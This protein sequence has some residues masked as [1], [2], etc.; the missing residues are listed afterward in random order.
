MPL[1]SFYDASAPSW[2]APIKSFHGEN[3]VYVCECKMDVIFPP[4]SLRLRPLLSRNLERFVTS[5]SGMAN[6]SNQISNYVK[7]YSWSYAPSRSLLQNSEPRLYVHN[8]FISLLHRAQRAWKEKTF[9]GKTVLWYIAIYI[10][11]NAILC[12]HSGFAL[13]LQFASYI[14]V[15]LSQARKTEIDFKANKSA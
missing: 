9:S 15:N 11:I 4:F 14:R 6:K 13:S 1:K 2:I 12:I 10:L 5:Y 8:N 3:I 7:H